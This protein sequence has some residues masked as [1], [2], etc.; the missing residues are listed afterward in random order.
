MPKTVWITTN[1]GKF[2]KRWEYQTC[3]LRN[4]YAGQEAKIRIRH[5]PMDWFQIEKGVCQSCIL[6]PCLFYLYAE[7][8]IRNAGLEEAQAGIKIARGNINNIDMQMTPALW[9]KVKRD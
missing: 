4:L 5:G 8:T 3:L 9:Q 1:C 6:S 7:Y 2:F